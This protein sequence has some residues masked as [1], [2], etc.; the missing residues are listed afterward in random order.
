MD[1]RPAVVANLNLGAKRRVEIAGKTAVAGEDHVTHEWVGIIGILQKQVSN[2]RPRNIVERSWVGTDLVGILEPPRTEV[3]STEMVGLVAVCVGN[4]EALEGVNV[5]SSEGIDLL[6]VLVIELKGRIDG[7]SD[8]ARACFG[9]Q[10]AAILVQ[11]GPGDVGALGL[12]CSLETDC[13]TS[14]D[15][16]TL[17]SIGLEDEARV[18]DPHGIITH[19]AV[20]LCRVEKNLI[21]QMRKCAED[22]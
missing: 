11:E 4:D 15:K 10:N 17:D 2:G 22:T 5:T 21:T 1:V 8:V 12:V 19:F 6:D 14:I 3:G 7:N 9:R 18:E 16:W 13:A 20:Y